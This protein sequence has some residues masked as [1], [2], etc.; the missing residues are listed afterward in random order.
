M[1]ET[2]SWLFS[3]VTLF[4]IKANFMTLSPSFFFFFYVI[5]EEPN[6]Q[7]D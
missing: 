5:S 7:K 1:L 2:M 3:M 6:T 4:F